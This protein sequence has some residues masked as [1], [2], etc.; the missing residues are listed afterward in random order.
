MCFVTQT[1]PGHEN[2]AVNTHLPLLGQHD[3]SLS[4][5]FSCI[6]ALLAGLLGFEEL[7][8]FREQDA[9]ETHANGDA[10]LEDR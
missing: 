4:P 8:G 1:Y 9:N 3:S 5:E 2:D 7:F 10:S 6:C